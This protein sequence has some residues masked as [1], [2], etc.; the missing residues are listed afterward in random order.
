MKL[1][2]GLVHDRE[3][4]DVSGA[5]SWGVAG[6]FGTIM[7]YEMPIVM[8]FSSPAL[9]TQCAGQPCGYAETDKARSSDQKLKQLTL[10]RL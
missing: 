3:N 7:S 6:N 4:V 5:Y 8:Y 10:L 1:G 2:L 9:A